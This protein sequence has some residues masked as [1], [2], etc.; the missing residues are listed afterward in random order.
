MEHPLSK[1]YEV[2]WGKPKNKTVRVEAQSRQYH[3][4]WN[5]LLHNGIREPPS[6]ARPCDIKTLHDMALTRTSRV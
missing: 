3:T 2:F 6:N 5:K 4:T 1:W